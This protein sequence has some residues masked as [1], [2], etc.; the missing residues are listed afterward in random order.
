MSIVSINL[1]AMPELIRALEALASDAGIEA[2]AF[3][4]HVSAAGVSGVST[5]ALWA[6]GVWADAELPGLR[7]RLSLAR[8]ATI[9]DPFGNGGPM[10]DIDESL[11]S[12][13]PPSEAEARARAVA[14]ALRAGTVTDD[15]AA[16][17]AKLASDPYFADELFASLTPEELATALA[18]IDRDGVAHAQGIS[19]SVALHGLAAV[20][21]DRAW[22]TFLRGHD[23][24]ETS[25]QRDYVRGLS[26]HMMTTDDWHGVTMVAGFLNAQTGTPGW[27]GPELSPLIV[28]VAN[29]DLLHEN[30][31]LLQPPSV[32]TRE[33]IM[34]AQSNGHSGSLLLDHARTHDVNDTTFGVLTAHEQVRDP[35]GRA[36]FVVTERAGIERIQ[37]L[38]E[39][40]AGGSPVDSAWRRDANAWSY[41]SPRSTGMRAL[42]WIARGTA[43]IDAPI[44]ARKIFETGGA[45]VTTPEGILMAA[46]GPDFHPVVG[47]FTW[48]PNYASVFAMRGGTMYGEVFIL[49]TQSED[50]A[51]TLRDRIES[52][53]V[54][55]SGELQLERTLRHERVH[56]EQWANHGLFQY[57]VLY[58]AFEAQVGLGQLCHN[59]FEVAAGLEDGGYASCPNH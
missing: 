5:T 21:L 19:D 8:A 41:G 58:L 14:E 43:E 42:N 36:Y 55:P 45:I 30:D 12:D 44:T 24:S 16:S 49:N 54:H 22:Q 2:V 28:M 25:A 10:V 26:T 33:W 4:G 40:L 13:L 18:A 52:S 27:A 20:G 39:L 38:T 23:G 35:T 56:A 50:P 48:L 51:R 15:G 7:R 53:A 47:P 32:F 31:V 34:N 29:Y 46:P 3:D 1:D 37:F 17:L 57:P 9:T 11:V 59:P 6:V